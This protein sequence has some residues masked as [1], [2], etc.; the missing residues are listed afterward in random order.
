M[1]PMAM[2]AAGT[3][4]ADNRVSTTS[5]LAMTSTAEV[6]PKAGKVLLCLTGTSPC[7]IAMTLGLPVVGVTPVG[8]SHIPQLVIFTMT[9]EV[10]TTPAAWSL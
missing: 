5:T 1:A 7:T 9:I 3:A 2:L 4:V 8:V 10:T 6:L